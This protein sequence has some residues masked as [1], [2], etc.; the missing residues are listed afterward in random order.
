V[1]L[2]SAFLLSILLFWLSRFV[3]PFSSM[4]MFPLMSKN[5]HQ[6]VTSEKAS[7][8]LTE[9]TKAQVFTRASKK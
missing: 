5:E 6:H 9:T 2:S 8:L 1:L 4:E 3:I 7:S